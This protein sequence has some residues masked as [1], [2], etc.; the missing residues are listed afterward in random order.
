MTATSPVDAGGGVNA[1]SDTAV[2][3]SPQRDATVSDAHQP[4]QS[5]MR[6]L[7][8]ESELLLEGILF[9]I[10][11]GLLDVCADVASE[12]LDTH[13]LQPGRAIIA[14]DQHKGHLTSCA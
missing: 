11:D 8:G 13:H 3:S 2:K 14:T 7:S 4:Q 10:G 1:S 6:P 9:V 12:F 5:V